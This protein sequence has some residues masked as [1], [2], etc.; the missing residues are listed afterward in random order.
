MKK[1]GAHAR[2]NPFIKHALV[3][4]KALGVLVYI[5]VPSFGATVRNMPTLAFDTYNEHY[6]YNIWILIGGLLLV[7]AGLT[8]GFMVGIA[9]LSPSDEYG[10][11]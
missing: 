4:T 8:Q 1:W 11:T 2:L 9:T 5:V 3:K 10:K 7:G 6:G